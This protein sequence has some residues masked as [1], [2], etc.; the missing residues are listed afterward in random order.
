MNI[1]ECAPTEA[2]ATAYAVSPSA[3]PD[4]DAQN[5][6]RTLGRPSA[7]LGLLRRAQRLGEVTR[8]ALVSLTDLSA[9]AA[10]TAVA[11]TAG[12]PAA[13][14]TAGVLAVLCISGQHRLRICLRVSDQVGRIVAAATLPLLVVL[15]WTSAGAAV[16][17]AL[18]S[19]GFVTAFRAAAYIG[20]RWAHRCGLFTEPAVIVGA[21][22]LSRQ[23]AGLMREHTELGLR[24]Y[25]FLGSGGTDDSAVLP[26]L[27]QAA[28]LAEVVTR[29][30][31]QRVILCPSDGLDDDLAYVI[32]DARPLRADVYVVPRL[33]E[34]G[35]AVPRACLD[36][37]WGIPLIPLRRYGQGPVSRLAKRVFD[38]AAATVLIIVLSPLLLALAVAVRI[39]SRRP[40]LF[41]QVRVV[42]SGRVAPI[43][44]LRTLADHGDPDTRWAV[45]AEWCT[46]LQRRLR[47]SHLDELPQLFNVLR[48]EMS[49]VGPRPER[50]YFAERFAHEVPGY[51]DRHRVRAG[52]TGWAQVHGLHG[53]T[54]IRDRARFDNQYIEY[55]SLWL[56]LV[57]LARTLTTAVTSAGQADRRSGSSSSAGLPGDI[58]SLGSSSSSNSSLPGPA[59]SDLSFAGSS[60]GDY[61]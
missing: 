59:P 60:R 48:G 12:W 21:G 45:P 9:L 38:L 32:R 1:A 58:S 8:S 43:V 11:G 18:Y 2:Q 25:G 24:L 22:T 42:R 49:L 46:P 56:D 35:A 20:L 61:R 13:A 23:I 27:G 47:A 6:E 40:A 17:L 14:Y 19:A 26:V 37:V 4:A 7:W 44:K 34:L 5:R 16:R 31:I 10:A 41:R 3:L 30:K 51:A 39:Q 50:P 54:S 55:W 15:A 28:D 36:E 53:D 33:H 57:I 29:Y 52:M